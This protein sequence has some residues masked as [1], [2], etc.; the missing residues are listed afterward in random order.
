MKLT[1]ETYMELPHAER[2]ILRRL[3]FGATP[4]QTF[5]VPYK[6]LPKKVTEEQLQIIEAIPYDLVALKQT[7]IEEN[8]KTAVMPRE[9]GV[10][11]TEFGKDMLNTVEFI[12]SNKKGKTIELPPTQIE[13]QAGEPHESSFYRED[14]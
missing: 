6:P 14:A 5:R 11:K 4:A 10:N 9:W 12:E 7:L 13:E 8:D 2:R 1:Y 3:A